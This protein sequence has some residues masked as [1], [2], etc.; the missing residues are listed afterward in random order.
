MRILKVKVFYGCFDN[1]SFHSYGS[2]ES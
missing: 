2:D 1:I